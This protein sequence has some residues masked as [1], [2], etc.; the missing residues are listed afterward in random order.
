VSKGIPSFFLTN[1]KK[2]HA[3]HLNK[4]DGFTIGFVLTAA[5]AI[6]INGYLK[7]PDDNDPYKIVDSNSSVEVVDNTIE[8]EVP[9]YEALIEDVADPA[10]TPDTLPVT[11][12]QAFA[13]AR[14]EKGP[15]A[16]FEW[17]GKSY[18][19]SLSEEIVK[20]GDT[21]DSTRINLVLNQLPN[22]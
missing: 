21:L 14:Q 19:T 17:N 2:E 13:F 7:Q 22:K 18:T 5:I 12:S 16:I 3:M 20:P 10:I 9:H 1:I 4:T 6:L 11:F 15:G 8:M